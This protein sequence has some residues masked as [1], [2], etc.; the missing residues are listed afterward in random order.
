MVNILSIL[1]KNRDKVDK[2]D[3]YDKDLNWAAYEYCENH[4]GHLSVNN[5]DSWFCLRCWVGFFM[6]MALG[7][8]Q[9]IR[10]SIISGKGSYV[11]SLFN[12]KELRLH[13]VWKPG[14]TV[15]LSTLEEGGV[16]YLYNEHGNTERLIS[17]EEAIKANPNTTPHKDGGPPYV[18]KLK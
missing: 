9:E 18:F 6:G 7:I 2:I 1:F 8:S 16:V 3:K 10:E 14:H 17:Y 5:T 15:E 13:N 12:N 11:L 4:G